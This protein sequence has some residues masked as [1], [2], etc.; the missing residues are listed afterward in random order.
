MDYGDTVESRETRGIKW[1]GKQC[2]LQKRNQSLNFPLKPQ[3]NTFHTIRSEIEERGGWKW[4]FTRNSLF[5][6][7]VVSISEGNE[8]DDE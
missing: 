1:N 5:A 8:G 3:K 2:N 6:H 4:G 7:Y